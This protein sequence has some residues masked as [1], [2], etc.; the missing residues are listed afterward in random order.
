MSQAYI[1]R[2][3]LR[4]ARVLDLLA[5]H[6]RPMRLS[7]ISRSLGIS[8]SSLLGVLS[9]LEVLGWLER[10]GSRG[11]YR[12][13]RGLLEL[14]RKAF[15]QWDLPV[16]ARPFM[17][18]LADRLGESV[19]LGLLQGQHVVILACVEGKSD[20]RVISRP[21]TSLPL[22]AGAVGK[23]LLA[24][25]EPHEAKRFLERTALPRFTDR[26]ICDPAKFLEEVDKARSRGYAMDDE[27]YLKGVRAVAAPLSGPAGALGAIWLVGFSSRLSLEALDEAGKE[28]L[29]ISRLLSRL[30]FPQ[31]NG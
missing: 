30:V 23:V 17:E 2:S 5:T 11:A 24:S 1:P 19:F 16:V 18:Q 15:G 28:L 8:K 27:E 13:G 22:L 12:T 29:A 4:A 20:M 25:M 7:E 14:S 9:A 3:V 31:T 10:E 6:G 26:S 21:G